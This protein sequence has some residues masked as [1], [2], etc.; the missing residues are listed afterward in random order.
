[1]P[2][3]LM[4]SFA[5]QTGKKPKTVEKLWKK[6]EKLVKK[7]YE[8]DEENKRFYPLV[9]GCLKN[10]LGIHSEK[11]ENDV[12]TTATMG[13]YSFAPKVGDLQ[14]R[15]PIDSEP[16]PVESE[17]KTDSKY[18]KKIK[19]IKKTLK[20]SALLE[21]LDELMS[22]NIEYFSNKFDSPDEIVD[23]S[24]DAVYKYLKIKDS[25]LDELK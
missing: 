8:I 24:F 19:K 18:Y 17:V 11:I 16:I 12:I 22:K 20:E 21:D 13:S 14:R 2:T 23:C 6:C 7:K 15:Q 3:P 10:L 5:E 4:K 1:M 9:V 25:F